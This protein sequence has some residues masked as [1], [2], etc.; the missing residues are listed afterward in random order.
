MAQTADQMIELFKQQSARSDKGLAAAKVSS[1]YQ[2]AAV[3]CRQGVKARLMRALIR[4]KSGDSPYDSLCE[5]VSFHGEAIEAM[6]RINGDA[7]LTDSTIERVGF[8]AYLVGANWTPFDLDGFESDRLLDGVL[9]NHLF[10]RFDKTRWE[11]GMT[12]LRD[13]GSSLAIA[14]YSCY[15]ELIHSSPQERSAIVAKLEHLFAERKADSFFS[16]GDQ[17]EGGGADNDVVVDY[18]LGALA[19]RV[20][21]QW[22]SRHC[23]RW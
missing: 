12:S 9:A 20:G 7:K 18:R 17:T 23:W 3:N 6:K 8:C 19:K 4:W 13:C 15:F 2:L 16:G 14:T 21:V 5:V 10:D 1:N 22:E 11:R